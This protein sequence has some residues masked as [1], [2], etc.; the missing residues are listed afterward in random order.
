MTA[1]TSSVTSAQAKLKF[2]QR[3][4]LAPLPC[5]QYITRQ[6]TVNGVTIMLFMPSALLPAV[7]I[8]AEKVS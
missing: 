1:T 7:S 4:I 2:S 3:L 5:Q 6:N 8:Q